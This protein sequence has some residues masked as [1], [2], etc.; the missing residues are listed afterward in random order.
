VDQAE[1]EPELC[2][3]ENTEGP[4]RLAEACEVRKISLLTF[5]SDLV[6]DGT[7][8][9]PYVES[10]TPAPLNVYGQ[11]KAEAEKLVLQ[12][13]PGALVVRTSAF[14]G[15]WD[16]HNF[17][18]QILRKIRKSKTAW[19]PADAVVS[20]T[21]VPDLVHACLDLIVDG[22]SGIWHLANNGQISWADLAR[23][24]VRMDDEP[25][26]LIIAK[27]LADFR[28]PARR[29]PFSV[30]ASQRGQLMPDLDDALGRYFLERHQIESK[31][32]AKL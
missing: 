23:K 32:M 31:E 4:A 17:V 26:E 21:Y 18:T 5:S 6:F 25:E 11:S 20:P 19:V 12:A 16:E 9:E 13:S 2:F 28:F 15:P 10:D 24:I 8:N 7:R 29:P 30:L 27:P 14:F 3:R 22:E 1:L